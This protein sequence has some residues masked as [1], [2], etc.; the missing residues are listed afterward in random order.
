MKFL[1]WKKAGSDTE[2]LT[3]VLCE[4]FDTNHPSPSK[5]SAIPYTRYHAEDN[6]WEFV[7]YFDRHPITRQP[8]KGYC[9][10]IGDEYLA[11]LFALVKDNF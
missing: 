8:G 3:D 6:A 5:L 1:I 9:I 2:D 7:H 4:W 11:L 10:W